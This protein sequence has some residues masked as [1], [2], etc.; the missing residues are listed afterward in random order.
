MALTPCL[1]FIG[2]AEEA[3]RFYVSTFP[4]AEVLHID[5][6]GPDD[7]GAAGTVKSADFRIGDLKLRCIDS[8]DVHAFGFTPA[9]S[10]FFDCEDEATFDAVF[11][12]L[13]D[14]GTVHMPPAR[15]PFAEK[16]AWFDDRYGVSWQ[17]SLA[18]EQ[19]MS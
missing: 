1:M 12:R 15:Y 5:H 13:S 3:I 10:F 11:D 8:P 18:S 7:A 17:L 2:H 6:N 9:V 14:Q 4:D 16:F 19:R